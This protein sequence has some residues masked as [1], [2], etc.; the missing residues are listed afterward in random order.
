VIEYRAGKTNPADAPSRRPDYACDERTPSHLLP[1]LQN[2][3]VVWKDDS[4]LALSISRVRVQ[5]DHLLGAGNTYAYT[6][7]YAIVR[8]VVN[9]VSRYEDPFEDLIVNLTTIIKSLQTNDNALEALLKSS[10][11]VGDKFA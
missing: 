2:K 7:L 8:A 3:L 6:G 1:I 4:D 10:R 11:D 9:A 5:R